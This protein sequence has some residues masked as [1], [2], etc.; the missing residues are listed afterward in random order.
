MS[1]PF[2]HKEYMVYRQTFLVDVSLLI[3]FSGR[4]SMAEKQDEIAAFLKERF[5]LSRNDDAP[6]ERMGVQSTD[7]AM[8]LFFYTDSAQITVM[9]PAYHSFKDIEK[10]IPLASEYIEI[11]RTAD[12]VRFELKKINRWQYESTENPTKS[13]LFREIFSEDM[14]KNDQTDH[15][16]DNE[17]LVNGEVERR[18]CNDDGE[19]MIFRLGKFSEEDERKKGYVQLQSCYASAKETTIQLLPQRLKEANQTLYD[20]FHWAVSRQVIKWMKDGT[21]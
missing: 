4:R 3:Y 9:A 1:F 6:K 14:I 5:N 12:T 17:A 2:P 13:E 10:L 16:L 15:F 11:M 7:G 21:I 20:A 18:F 19:K 8:R